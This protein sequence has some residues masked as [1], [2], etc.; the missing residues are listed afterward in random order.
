[1]ALLLCRE[2]DTQALKVRGRA[3]LALT[4]PPNPG[5]ILV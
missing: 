1:M 5:P 3:L 4:Q 2:G